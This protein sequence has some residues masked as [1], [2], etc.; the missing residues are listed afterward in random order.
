[1]KKLLSMLLVLIMAFSLYGCGE[2]EPSYDSYEEEAEVEIDPEEIIK[3]EMKAYITTE[4]MLSYKIAQIE[5]ISTFVTQISEKKYEVTGKVTI[6]DKYGDSYTGKYDAEVK[7]NTTDNTVRV[8][9]CDIE[10][11]TKDE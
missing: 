4:I 7:Y 8:T 6:L 9:D 1:M 5:N 11:P 10:R 3:E 2:D